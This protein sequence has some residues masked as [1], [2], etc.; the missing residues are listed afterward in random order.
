M[1][2]HSE[3]RQILLQGRDGSAFQAAVTHAEQKGTHTVVVTTSEENL[4]RL[5]DYAFPILELVAKQHGISLDGIRYFERGRDGAA[6]AVNTKNVALSVASASTY[7]Q[8]PRRGT[9]CDE[10]EVQKRLGNVRL[11]QVNTA[12]DLRQSVP[13]P[14]Q[15]TLKSGSR[16][17]RPR[18]PRPH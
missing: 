15:N 5:R 17:Q 7:P 4:P 1:T 11:P 10:S 6:F 16:T 13:T 12:L 9:W 2:T 3:D 8:S 14:K 18:Y